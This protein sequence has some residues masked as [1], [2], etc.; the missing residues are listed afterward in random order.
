MWD[1]PCG[2]AAG[3]PASGVDHSLL[4][5]LHHAALHCP[6]LRCAAY[7]AN[8]P[9]FRVRALSPGAQERQRLRAEQDAAYYESLQA[10]GGSRGAQ[11]GPGGWLLGS[12]QRLVLASWLT[13]THSDVW[14]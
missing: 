11:W 6:V 3:A 7:F 2:Q 13:E 14:G 10:G 9:R 8:D 4:G 1:E 12:W 5:Q